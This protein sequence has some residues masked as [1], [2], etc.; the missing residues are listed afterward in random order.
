MD[1]VTV[2]PVENPSVDAATIESLAALLP[3]PSASTALPG[4][5]RAAETPPVPAKE[6]V[7]EG[8]AAPEAA[9]EEPAKEEPAPEADADALAR[10][11]AAAKKAREGS[12]RYREAIERERQRAAEVQRA[13]AEAEQ[14][15]REAVEA[16]RLR[17]QL[18]KDPYKTLKE[19]GMTD[20]ALAE[21]ALREGTPEQAILEL[22]SVLEQ[23]RQARLAIE[24]R[25]QSEREAA[26]A[27]QAEQNFARVA[28]NDTKYPQLAQLSAR[29]QLVVARAALE[30][31]AENGYE[32]S[33]LS[34]DQVA[35]ACERFLSPKKAKAAVKAPAPAPKPAAKPVTLTNAAATTKATASRPWEDLTEDE[36]IAQLSALLPDP[37]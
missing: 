29:A 4:A 3:D 18:T 8:E 32:V 20:Q 27:R 33:H 26:Q 22:K 11:E 37:S 12:R 28:D 21:R 15:R 9:K 17:E 13:A 19:L 14:L 24:Q 30:Q 6:H 16:K 34:D 23:E 31:I 10:A 25:L 36:Q 1:V 7:E 35:D 2:S 5:E